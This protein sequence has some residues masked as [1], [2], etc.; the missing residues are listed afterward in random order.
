MYPAGH[1]DVGLGGGGP[2]LLPPGDG[3]V[4]DAHHGEQCDR[5]EPEDR[6]PDQPALHEQQDQDTCDE[7]SVPDHLERHGGEEVGQVG[8]VTVDSLDQLP[9]GVVL[10]EAEVETDDVVGEVGAQGV[11]RTP[12]DLLGQIGGPDREPLLGDGD[13]HEGGGEGDQ[14]GRSVT[15]DRP[16][17][18]PLD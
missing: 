12:A 2:D 7:S 15:G 5:G 13:P 3:D 14:G 6:H 18:E 1:V 4:V 16:V 10:V 17:D 8:D 9:G 11:R